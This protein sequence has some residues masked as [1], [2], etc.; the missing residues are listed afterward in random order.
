MIILEKARKKIID[1]IFQKEIVLGIMTTGVK[2]F[3]INSSFTF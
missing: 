1:A 3:V 2:Q